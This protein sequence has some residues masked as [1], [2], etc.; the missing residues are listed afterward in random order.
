MHPGHV[1]GQFK[2]LTDR[3]PLDNNIE[4]NLRTFLG[5]QIPFD[6]VIAYFLL[7]HLEKYLLAMD[8]SIDT[9]KSLRDMKLVCDVEMQGS[10][11]LRDLH[12]LVCLHLS[13]WLINILSAEAGFRAFR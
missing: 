13:F 10:T 2:H 4:K 1:A 11:T 6:I 7:G 8:T 12:L 9:R 5:I 3:D